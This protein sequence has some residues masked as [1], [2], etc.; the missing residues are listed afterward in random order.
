VR[1]KEKGAPP[2]SLGGLPPPTTKPYR[3]LIWPCL[4]LTVGICSRHT[5]A[6]TS[7][8][9]RS[10]GHGFHPFDLTV[11]IRLPSYSVRR[12]PMLSFVHSLLSFA[13]SSIFNVFIHVLCYNF[14]SFV[15]FLCPLFIISSY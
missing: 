3:S 6:T 8:I 12:R 4:H 10:N 2:Y 11:F 9:P 15:V 1:E 7:K 14:V 13:Y 5:L